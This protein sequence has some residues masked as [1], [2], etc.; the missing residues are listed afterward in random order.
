[1]YEIRITQEATPRQLNDLA[2]GNLDEWATCSICTGI[3]FA[4]G[5]V[6]EALISSIRS[7][8][9]V[10]TKLTEEMLKCSTNATYSLQI[11][12]IPDENPC[13]NIYTDEEFKRQFSGFVKIYIS[14]LC[15]Q[16]DPLVHEKLCSA[17][18]YF[19]ES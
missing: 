10:K 5:A 14:V 15:K 18:N 9:K 3:D 4:S 13:S 16:N 7:G 2:C 11:V 19:F 1:M 8:S 6:Q 12:Q 17:V